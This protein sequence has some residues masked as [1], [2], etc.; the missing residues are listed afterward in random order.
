MV[1][2]TKVGMFEECC[3]GELSENLK[4]GCFLNVDS[5]AR[6]ASENS[7]RFPDTQILALRRNLDVRLIR[8]VFLS[9]FIL[10]R[11]TSY[12]V[13]LPNGLQIV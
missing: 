9:R 2:L 13:S 10:G 12:G 8:K 6:L 4:I 7:Q 3:F 11:T 1:Q 5:D